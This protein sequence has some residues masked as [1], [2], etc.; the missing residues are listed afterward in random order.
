MNA[1]QQEQGQG[2]G[3]GQRQGGCFEVSIESDSA[4]ITIVSCG[5]RHEGVC[6]SDRYAKDVKGAS[7]AAAARRGSVARVL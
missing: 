7:P 3:Q 4:S 5:E 6:A 1:K 2:Q